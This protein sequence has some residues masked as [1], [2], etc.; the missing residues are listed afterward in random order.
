MKKLLLIDGNSVLFRAY[1]ATLY[2]RKMATSNGIPT[3]AVYG[4]INM[5]NKA[6][7]IIQPDYVLVAWDKDSQTFRKEQ[8]AAYKGTRKPLD[9][10]LV[11]QFPIV[12]EFLDAA[13]IQRYEVQGFEA[14]DIIGSMAKQTPEMMTTILS[15]DK[16]L[17]Q[18]IDP[19]THILLMKK[20]LTEMEEMDQEALLE[21][22]ELTPSQIIDLKGL[23]GDTSDNIPGVA[24]VGE[25]T[26]VKLLKEYSTLEG[27][28]DNIESI[29]GKLKEKL[30]NDKDN[31][32]LS[33]QLATIYR[34]IEF[35]FAP[36][37]CQIL[38]KRIK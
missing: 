30:E 21:K 5:V 26:A 36:G 1:Y 22:F 16:D 23:M 12:R 34:D 31:A 17:L 3:N 14:D 13:G 24:G 29:K 9:D 18:L 38:H 8:Y 2:T 20:G 10:E 7:D 19:T 33:K 4:F 32:Y 28:Y 25:K 27:V 37:D 11:V 15:S 35:P 6:L